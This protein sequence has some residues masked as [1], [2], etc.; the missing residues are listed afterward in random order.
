M[1]NKFSWLILGIIQGTILQAQIQVTGAI[2]SQTKIQVDQ[3]KTIKIGRIPIQNHIGT[4]KQPITKAKG[5][6]LLSALSGIEL[7]DSNPK[8]FSRYIYTIRAKDGYAVTFSWNELYNTSI[9]KRVFLLTETESHPNN[10]IILISK[11]DRYTGR[12]FV[13]D[14]SEIHIERK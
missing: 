6:P 3:F 11:F 5:I 10:G 12:R 13:K 8:H 7:A 14:V 4:K 1:N 9:G 2:Q